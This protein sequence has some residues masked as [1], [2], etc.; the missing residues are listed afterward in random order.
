MKLYMYLY[1]QLI[2][3]WKRR[4]F[5]YSA[6]LFR[7]SKI[8]VNEDLSPKLRPPLNGLQIEEVEKVSGATHTYIMHVARCSRLFLLS[9]M[10]VSQRILFGSY[11]LS[12]MPSVVSHDVFPWSPVST[13]KFQQCCQNSRTASA[14]SICKVSSWAIASSGAL[15]VSCDLG[16]PLA[17][18]CHTKL[19][20]SCLKDYSDLASVSQY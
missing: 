11:R 3:S 12:T 9:E 7:D 4:A 2:Q 19:F 18:L 16:L 14:E 15:T 5:V 10:Q 1:I 13:Y 20:Y 8:S 6:Y 17:S